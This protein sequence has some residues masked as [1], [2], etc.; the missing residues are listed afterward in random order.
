MPRVTVI[1]STFN[2]GKWLPD[3]IRSVRAQSFSDFEHF[4]IDDGSTDDTARAVLP[5]LSNRRVRFFRRRHAGQVAQ[6][7]WAVKKCRSELVAFL[8]SDDLYRKDHLKLLV[9]PFDRTSS[10]DFVLGRFVLRGKGV[11][12]ARVRDFFHP[13]RTIPL[14][15]VEVAGGIL[16]ARR[17]SVL[18]A[19][20]FVG[21][22]ADIRLVT[23]MRKLGFS[24]KKVRRATYVYRFNIARDSQALRESRPRVS[25]V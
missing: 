13:A 15:R 23:R 3:A 4:I 6:L 18:K 20:G 2:R 11:K 7:N 16:V 10:P 17:K 21:P 5:F 12:S 19:G 25:H 9:A 24:E 8:D 1:T 14:S 22:F